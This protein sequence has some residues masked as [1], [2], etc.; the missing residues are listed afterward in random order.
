MISPSAPNSSFTLLL[1]EAGLGLVAIAIAFAF[2]HLLSRFF[3]RSEAAFARLGRRKR[4]ACA[5]VGA[6][7]FLLRLA[8]LP[9]FP[10]PLPFLPNDFSFLLAADTF[11]W[12][13]A[14]P[15]PLMWAHFERFHAPSSPHTH[16]CNFPAR[17]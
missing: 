15:A 9:L 6:S 8:L 11:G 17:G 3:R 16:P 7:A 5:T 4:L 2:P 12:T 13:P 10:A 14:N 1:I